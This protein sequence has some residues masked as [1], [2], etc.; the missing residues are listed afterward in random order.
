MLQGKR[1]VQQVCVY[2]TVGIYLTKE[3]EMLA[4]CVVI[5]KQRSSG[6]ITVQFDH[7]V[8]RKR[9][10]VVGRGKW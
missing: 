4:Q 2:V 5:H 9:L 6:D 10:E 8:R 3:A 7:C 1:D